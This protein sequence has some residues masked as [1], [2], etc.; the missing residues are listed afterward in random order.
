MHHIFGLKQNVTDAWIVKRREQLSKQINNTD[1]SDLATVPILTQF[2]RMV[3]K[4]NNR[5]EEVYP[6]LSLTWSIMSEGNIGLLQWVIEQTALHNIT[7][8]VTFSRFIKKLQ[9]FDVDLVITKGV[10]REQFSQ[11]VKLA[12]DVLRTPYSSLIAPPVT[13]TQYADLGYIGHYAMSTIIK[14]TNIGNYRGRPDIYATLAKSEL[15]KLARQ[16]HSQGTVGMALDDTL[17]DIY[18]TKFTGADKTI[19]TIDDTAFEIPRADIVRAIGPDGA[20]AAVDTDVNKA[21]RAGWPKLANKL[22]NSATLI[23]IEDVT[24]KLIESRSAA[25]KAFVRIMG[26]LHARSIQSAPVFTPADSKVLQIPYA[27]FDDE[28]C[29]D[30]HEWGFTIPPEWKHATPGFTDEAMVAGKIAAWSDHIIREV[31]VPVVN[32]PNN[33]NVQGNNAGG[34]D[35]AGQ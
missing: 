17:V 25:S 35:G 20:R 4:S 14:E 3:P 1:V 23:S 18:R 10:P 26:K 5:I 2:V 6:Q 21:I 24:S 8:A 11:L 29:N 15:E 22:P 31:P 19:V 34:G 9:Y 30:F 16:L 27:A 32:E 28:M 33:Q 13:L 12:R 7:A